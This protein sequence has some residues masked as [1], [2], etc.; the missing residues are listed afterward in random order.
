MS[1]V[2]IS[3]SKDERFQTEK[4][5]EEKANSTYAEKMVFVLFYV[6]SPSFIL[7]C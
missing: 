1:L 7:F 6:C 4:E 3:N 2:T 5:K